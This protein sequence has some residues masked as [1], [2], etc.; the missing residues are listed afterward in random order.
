M[1]YLQQVFMITL[2]LLLPIDQARSN[3][4]EQTFIAAGLVDI[5]S[6]DATIRVDLVNSDAK[7]NYFR[8]DFYGGL[9]RAYLQSDVALR[10]ARAQRFLTSEHPD[11]SLEILDAARPR[12]VSQSMYDKMKGTRFEKYVADPARGSMHNYGVAVD[13]TIV[14]ARGAEL[15][16]GFS[17]FRKSTPAMLWQLARMKMGARLTDAQVRNRRL[18]SG[19]MLKAGFLPLAHEWWHFDGLPKDEARKRYA[20]IE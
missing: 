18:L 16:M 1:K 7:K 13:L 15:D 10:L 19:V 6:I 9:A 5:H 12:R 2:A 8:E 11:L 17:P 4:I 3:E 20:I 14:D